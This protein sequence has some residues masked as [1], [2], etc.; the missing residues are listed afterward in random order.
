M[1]L[2]VFCSTLLL[3]TSLLAQPLP[4]VAAERGR[5]FEGRAGPHRSVLRPRDRS[6]SR[7]RCGG[8]H[9][10]R[11]QA[12]LL[13]GARLSRQGGRHADAA[14]RHFPA[15]LDDQDHG[16]RRRPDAERGRSPAAQSRL[17][18]VP[19]FVRE[20]ERRRR[21]G[22]RRDHAATGQPDLHPRPVPPYVGITYGGRGTTAVH[23]LYPSGSARQRR[24]SPVR[25]SSPSSSSLPLLHPP[26]TVWDYSF[27][28]DVLG[29]VIEKG[30]RQAA[31]R[32]P[33]EKRCG[34]R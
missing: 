15:G 21:L 20:D 9:R 29:L 19:A 6:Q 18:R 3:S 12:R 14:R 1:R 10:A 24:S 4:P 26:G 33:G 22:Q 32:L 8:G 34:T 28:T 31:E 11:R 30:Q 27:S 5:V 17:D 25:N 7:A 23:K 13:Q 16:Q 2:P